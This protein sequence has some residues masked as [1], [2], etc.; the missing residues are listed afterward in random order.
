MSGGKMN[1]ETV[2]VSVARL[3]AESKKGEG[4]ANWKIQA[5]AGNHRLSGLAR[6]RELAKYCRLCSGIKWT[7]WVYFYLANYYYPSV[8]FQKFC[9]KYISQY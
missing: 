8:L 3:I 4:V 9:R 5:A 2:L 1:Y 6:L 7:G